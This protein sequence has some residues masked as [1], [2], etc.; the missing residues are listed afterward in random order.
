MKRLLSTGIAI[1]LLLGLGILA[2]LARPGGGAL[3]GAPRS[4]AAP[5]LSQLPA[6]VTGA[7]PAATA[8]WNAIA[9]AL[10]NTAT[11]PDAQALAQAITGTQQVLQWNAAAQAFDAYIPDPV[12]PGGLGTNFAL[13]LGQPYMV[14]VGNTAPS[15]FSLVGDV[16]PQT[17]Q[18]GAVQFSLLGGSPCQWNF[19]SLPLD[20][21]SITTA[22]QLA[23]AIGNVEQVLQWNAATSVQAFDAYIP[24]PVFPGG[25]GTNFSTHIGY[26]YFVC[27]A[28]SKS[29]P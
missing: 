26:P 27:M 23:D 29:W 16:P 8:N 13:Q 20:Q 7:A 18:T 19:I 1:A 14:Q 24:D 5:A 10:D 15:V 6:A 25:L 12:F 3:L 21:G 11:L 28:T 9:M 17:G 4:A 22:Q 2:V